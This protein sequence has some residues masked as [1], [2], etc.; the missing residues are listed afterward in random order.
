MMKLTNTKAMLFLVGSGLALT[1]PAKAEMSDIAREI[2]VQRACQTAIWASGAVETWDI[3]NGIITDLSGKVGDVVQLSQPM[4][5]QHGFL[6][7]NDVTP[8]TVAA[9]TTADG[10]LVVEVPPAT[11]KVNIFGTF[12]DS[13]MRPVSDVGE[14]GTDEGKGG[15]YL[16]LPFGYEGDVPDEGYFVF[17]LESYSINFAFRPVHRGDGTLKEAVSHMRDN[18][19]VYPLAKADNPPETVFLD[20][21]GKAWDT[22]P[23][24][25]ETYF[26][27][28]W[29]I[30][31]NEPIRERDKSMYGMLKLINIE[32]GKPFDT[33]SE[34]TSIYI[35]GAQC[36]F[37]YLQERFFTPG[38]VLAPFYGADNQWQV[39]NVPQDQAELGF[40]FEADGIPLT[41]LRAQNYFFLTYYPV[42]LGGSSFYLVG[43]RDDQGDPL[44]GTDTYW[45]HVPADTRAEDFWSVIVYSTMSKG[46]IRDAERVGISSRELD[47]LEVNDDGSVDISLAPEAPE[48]L[49]SNWIPT[50]EDWF[51]IFRFY[52][53]QEP[54]FDKSFVL[55]NIGKL[56]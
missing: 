40:P 7:A 21:T 38:Q 36:A 4:T 55:A 47:S 15:K 14:A 16:F 27:D 20:A 13:W 29:N 3:A 17:P 26:Q 23:Y 28:I 33:S 11:E 35:D 39:M 9:L 51:A 34:W 25:D 6:T 56:E 43:L 8:Y 50:G 45:L 31:Q 54:V 42:N 48:G 32:K 44:N 52:G 41:D 46:F 22:L 53:P 12:V 2:A 49:A 5:S 30:V 1:G 18:L 10:P 19:R 37:D 24:Y